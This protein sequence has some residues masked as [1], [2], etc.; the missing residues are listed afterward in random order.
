MDGVPTPILIDS[1]PHDLEEVLTAFQVT[2]EM[3]LFKRFSRVR[4]SADLASKR[5]LAVPDEAIQVAV[6]EWRYGHGLETVADME[7]FLCTRRISLQDVA[8]E[9][10][11][12]L[13]EQALLH[14]VTRTQ[15]KPYFEERRSQFDEADV[16]WIYSE[17][18]GL[19]EELFTQVVEEDRDFCRLARLHS[20]HAPTRPGGGYLGRLRRGDLAEGISPLVFG[21]KP[22]EVAGPLKVSGGYAIYTILQRYQASLTD[23]I[24]AEVSERIFR[25]WLKREMRREGIDPATSDV[26]VCT[27]AASDEEA[28]QVFSNDQIIQT[29]REYVQGHPLDPS[30]PVSA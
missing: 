13:L 23:D 19:I 22:G 25:K 6:D 21:K 3:G 24:R 10:E 29:E 9:M 15:I 4:F 26:S 1:R 18:A 27:E 5:G 14:E 7:S 16:C 30:T 12:R 2:D 11:Y 8:R 20:D 28:S 17:E